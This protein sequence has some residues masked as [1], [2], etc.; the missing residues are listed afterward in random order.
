MGVA[1]SVIL[2]FL[3]ADYFVLE[4]FFF[5][6]R[7][8]FLKRC[9]IFCFRFAADFFF[10]GPSKILVIFHIFF[11]CFV[12]NFRCFVLFFTGSIIH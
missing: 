9:F 4:F 12:L 5:R 10:G 7:S 6:S 11:R 3:D 2:F 1:L 8:L